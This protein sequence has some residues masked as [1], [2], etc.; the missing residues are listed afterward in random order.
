MATLDLKA[1]QA[2][3]RQL[4]SETEP[5]QDE[6]VVAYDRL[7]MEEI[8]VGEFDFDGDMDSASSVFEAHLA[9]LAATGLGLY[10]VWEWTRYH[11]SGGECRSNLSNDYGT[12]KSGDDI[13]LVRS[14]TAAYGILRNCAYDGGQDIGCDT[15]ERRIA[16]YVGPLSLM[17]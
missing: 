11:G 1:R 16:W 6:A 3:A 12:W 7:A 8:H 10:A 9:S 14:A 13:R 4:V 5:C 17:A 15:V 2:L